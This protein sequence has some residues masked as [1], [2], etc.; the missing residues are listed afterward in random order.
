MGNS[1]AKQTNRLLAEQT[2][3][4]NAL[5]SELGARSSAAYGQQNDIRNE[6]LGNYRNLYTGTFGEDGSGGGGGGGGPAFI[7]I[8][9]RSS[10]LPF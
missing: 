9:W 5:E 1:G 2:Q 10:S 7:S 3:R 4:A 8:D 6:L